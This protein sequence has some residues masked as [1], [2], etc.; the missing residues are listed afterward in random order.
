MAGQ[1][2]TAAVIVRGILS[3]PKGRVGEHIELMLR[4]QKTARQS[5]QVKD[6]PLETRVIICTEPIEAGRFRY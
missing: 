4:G 2:S 3:E 5:L 1:A 6:I